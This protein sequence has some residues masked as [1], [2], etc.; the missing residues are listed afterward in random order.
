M[1]VTSDNAK[2]AAKAV[3]GASPAGWT[4]GNDY[5]PGSQHFFDSVLAKR[6]TYECDWLNDVVHFEKYRDK[7]V[8]EIGC[9]A[10]YDAYQFC[11]NGADYT[12]IDITPANPLLVKQHLSYYGYAPTTHEMDAEKMNF[13]EEF[14]FVYSFGVLHHIPD[15][16]KVLNNCY[17]ALK[18]D[19]EACIIVYYKYS[20]FYVLSTVLTAWIL[21]GGFL[22]RSLAQQRGLIEYSE[23]DQLPLVNVYSKKALRKMMEKAGFN[24]DRLCVRKLVHEDLPSLR[25]IWRFYKYI[26]SSW[27]KKLGNY[28]GWYVC[29]RAVKK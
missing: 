17:S 19:G 2:N 10:G 18:K 26:P 22:K 7:K 29:V 24:V 16:Q 6:F 5:K 13:K 28:W 9:G 3:W 14:D 8:L 20:I 12:G 21:R 4:F 11:K 25:L 23:S 15:M 27:L 1:S